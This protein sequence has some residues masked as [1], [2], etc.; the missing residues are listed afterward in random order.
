MDLDTTVKL[1]E[2]TK[3]SNK[4][5]SSWAGARKVW[6]REWGIGNSR[7]KSCWGAKRKLRTRETASSAG[8]GAMESPQHEGKEGEVSLIWEVHFS[9]SKVWD[10]V[11]QKWRRARVGKRVLICVLV[12]IDFNTKCKAETLV[13]FWFSLSMTCYSQS[14]VC[15]LKVDF[16]LD[17]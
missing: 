8:R 15:I 2:A 1:I 11:M 5:G 12:K 9:N 17:A 6:A 4:A 16:I 7:G 13:I 3:F 14:E 10:R